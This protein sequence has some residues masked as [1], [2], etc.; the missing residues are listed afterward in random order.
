MKNRSLLLVT[1]SFG[2]ALLTA[3]LALASQPPT[4]MVTRHV[5]LPAADALEMNALVDVTVQE[6]SSQNIALTGPPYVLDHTHLAVRQGLLQVRSSPGAGR[7]WRVG[8]PPPRLHLALTLPALRQVSLAGAGTL[9]SLTPLTAPT[10]TVLLAGTSQATLQ[11]ANRQTRVVL[12][13]A[14]TATLRG[15]TTT[16]QVQLTGIGTYHAFGL[17]SATTIAQLAGTGTE[18][19]MARRSLTAHL[20]GIG[21]IRYQGNPATIVRTSSGLGEIEAVR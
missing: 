20:T 6:G 13:G 2:V 16:Q 7:W 4:V 17:R 8:F 1:G 14:G 12:R 10:L 15:T 18:E 3:A 19:V 21:S 11:V 9:T 5:F